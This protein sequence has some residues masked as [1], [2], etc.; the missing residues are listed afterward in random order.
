ME[1]ELLFGGVMLLMAR[2]VSTCT[3]VDAV[4]LGTDRV[5]SEWWRDTGG[6]L[7]SLKDARSKWML[8]ALPVWS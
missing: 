1:A 2:D 6:N 3:G 5:A 4:K 8:C 7:R